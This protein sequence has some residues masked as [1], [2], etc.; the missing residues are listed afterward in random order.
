VPRALLRAR[1]SPRRGTGPRPVRGTGARSR[2]HPP[3]PGAHR[4]L[5]IL[6][7]GLSGMAVMELLPALP[8]R[9]LRR[10]DV[11]MPPEDLTASP[12]P[13]KVTFVPYALSTGSAYRRQG[14][15]RARR[16][17]RPRSFS[18][19][20]STL[21][22]ARSLEGR[23]GDEWAGQ[24]QHVPPARLPVFARCGGELSRNV[25][26]GVTRY[27]GPPPPAPNVACHHHPHHNEMPICRP[28][29]SARWGSCRSRSTPLHRPG[30]CV[31]VHGET[32]AERIT[33]FLE[34]KGVPSLGVRGLVAARPAG[35]GRSHRPRR[36]FSAKGGLT[37][38]LEGLDVSD[39]S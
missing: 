37:F 15:G 17:R 31:D 11:L 8:T 33:E 23:R 6:P 5:G 27:R 16:V 22:T 14:H 19:H 20:R 4:L 7:A 9:P 32:R 12:R 10:H 34:G 3:R 2:R 39:H 24:R 1:Q 29:A 38:I 18:A 25:R 13:R 21:R 26:R 30:S 35:S 36:L 28:R